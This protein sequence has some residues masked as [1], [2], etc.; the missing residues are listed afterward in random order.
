MRREGLFTMLIEVSCDK[1][2]DDGKIRPKIEFHPGLNTVMGARKATNSI[3]K[4]TFLLIVDYCFGGTDYTNLNTDIDDNVGPHTINFAFKF[5]DEKFFYSRKTD[6]PRKVYICN[7]KYEQISS[8]GLESFNDF[9][10]DKYGLTGRGNSFRDIIG[11]YFRIYGK[12]NDDEK[13]PLTAF[14]NDTLE[15]GIKRLLSL[16]DVYGKTADLEASLK[17][18]IEEEDAY[19]KAQKHKLI[20]GVTTKNG[21]K[22]NEK[23]IKE[24]QDRKATL[25]A[26]SAKGLLD[27]D[28]VQATH[29]AELKKKLA[30]LRRQKRRFTVQ[31]D[32]M[33]M[34]ID[35]DES[36]FKRDYSELTEFFPDADIKHIEAIDNFHRQLKKVLKNEYTENRER[37]ENIVKMIDIQISDLEKEIVSFKE[38]PNVST[39]ILEDYSSIENELESLVAANEYFEKINELHAATADLQERFDKIIAEVVSSL[40]LDINKELRR[41]NTIV[42]DAKTS[43]PKINIR[44]S[45]S[46][47]YTTPNDTGTGS[48]TRG[49]MLFDYVSLSNTPLPALIED[50]MTLKQ[51][52]DEAMIK[53]FELFNESKKQV[54][55]AIDKAESY[56]DDNTVP[57][58][59]SKTTVLEL[60]AGHELFGRAWNK[61][62]EK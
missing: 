50:S 14:R 39:A 55:V 49:M 57:P 48:R 54:F 24:L 8:M 61:S 5:D 9:L 47:S 17:K 62:E 53:L 4:T 7:E 35:I 37:L 43:A 33:K 1:F 12:D 18:A 10:M 21:V 26:G 42:C 27:L 11:G 31:L 44:D 51:I 52:E 3:G 59:F 16:Y 13:K 23:R 56:S 30:S 22:E 45:K 46:Y 36:S 19:K 2:I 38:I 29:I 34:D 6:E 41:L 20:S 58:V 32:A 15:Q 40:Q 60:S 25:T 28:S